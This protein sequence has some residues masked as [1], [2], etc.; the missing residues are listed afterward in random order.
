ME[1]NIK[2][3]SKEAQESLP[4]VKDWIEKELKSVN[5]LA[6]IE[7]FEE[8]QDPYFI[9]GMPK[10]ELMGPSPYETLAVATT[11]GN[12]QEIPLD[13]YRYMQ[14]ISDNDITISVAGEIHTVMA[15]EYFDLNEVQERNGWGKS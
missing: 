11:C 14:N 4:G 13:H 1:S 9:S 10:F 12:I 6:P 15:G 7:T 5:D 8:L 3:V 2:A